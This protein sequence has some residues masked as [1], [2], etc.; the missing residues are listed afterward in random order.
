[1]ELHFP[2][3]SHWWLATKEDAIATLNATGDRGHLRVPAGWASESAKV[4]MTPLETQSASLP[5]HPWL[6]SCKARV[7][8]KSRHRVKIKP[9]LAQKGHKGAPRKP[10]VCWLSS[11][12]IKC[13]VF[14]LPDNVCVATW[15]LF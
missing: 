2:V 6:P 14:S 7:S 3:K 1:M 11:S 8:G 12:S 9:S 5:E 10:F 13:G 15:W 4:P